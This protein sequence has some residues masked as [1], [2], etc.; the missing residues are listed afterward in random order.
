MSDGLAID[1]TAIISPDARVV[2]SSRGTP[3]R[4]G[5]HTHV[6][7]FVVIRPV[8]GDGAIEIGK[9]CYINPHCVLYSGSGIRFGDYVLIG[10][11]TQIVP[12]NHAFSRRDI[13]IRRQGFMPSRGGVVCEDDVWI[14]A[15]CVLLDGAHIERG[16][17]IAAGSVVNTR[18]PSY[19]IWGGTPARFIRKRE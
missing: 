13:P 7:E 12:A 10:P 5:A 9:H 14:G 6:Y 2:A 17:V 11:G 4:I 15:Q 8:G 16:A 1:P 18:V 19:E 3:I